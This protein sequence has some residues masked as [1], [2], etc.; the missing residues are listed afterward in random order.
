MG[1]ACGKSVL[2]RLGEVVPTVS[3]GILTADLANLQGE[4]ALLENTGVKLVHL[5]V[6]DGCFAPKM[7]FGP[8]LIQAM[9]TSLLK[10][11]HLM[12]EHPLEKV[13]EYVAAGADMITVHV[14]SDRH[15]HRVL[16]ALGAMSNATNPER[17]T[18]SRHCPES[19]NAG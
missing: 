15:I 5:D 8:P 4:L 18:G 1:Q 19:W 3:V 16:Q 11:V 12:I 14:E 10:D 7:T 13:G 17:G 6:M 9:R 2:D